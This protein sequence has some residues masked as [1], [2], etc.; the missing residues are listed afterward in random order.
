MRIT[1]AD[2]MPLANPCYSGSYAMTLDY[3]VNVIEEDLSTG[4]FDS[5]N[6]KYYP[7][8]VTDVL[9]LS[10]SSTISEVVVY[11]LLG[12]QM[13]VTKPNATQTQMD[14]SSLSTGTY[15]VKIS[16]DEVTKTVKVVKN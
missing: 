1:G 11:N 8:P 16:S 7:N 5:A 9:T 4:S 14:L 15:L 6:F 13:L 12:Q 2:F 10:Y 3:T